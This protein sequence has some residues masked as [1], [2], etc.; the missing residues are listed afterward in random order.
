[1]QLNLESENF[2]KGLHLFGKSEILGNYAVGI[3]K[4]F[5]SELKLS[6]QVRSGP[7]MTQEPS[8]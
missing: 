1:M 5:Q 4:T 7:S 8:S 2:M 3:Y 6:T